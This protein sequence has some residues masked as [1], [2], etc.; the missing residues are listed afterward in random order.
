MKS[1]HFQGASPLLPH[2]TWPHDELPVWA[3]NGARIVPVYKAFMV[4]AGAN[5]AKAS[6]KTITQVVEIKYWEN[7]RHQ[8]FSRIKNGD[9]YL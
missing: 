2:I 6:R 4:V 9:M 7:K 3:P 8:L 5:G 1:D